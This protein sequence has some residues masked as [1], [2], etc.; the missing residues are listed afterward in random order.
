MNKSVPETIFP[1]MCDDIRQEVGGK[2][3][4]MG[5]YADNI[6]L[7]KFPFNFPKICFQIHMRGC[8][9][10]FILDIYLETPD[11]KLLLMKDF[12][13]Q[14]KDELSDERRNLILNINRHGIKFANPGTCSL[15]LIFN[16]EEE[17]A[18]S[19]PFEVSLRKD[20]H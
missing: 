7:T 16:Q 8:P 12:N 20:I 9:R 2:V 18:F 3:S 11:E 1:I 5:V 14:A 6:V 4:L 17:S 10:E 15:K 19:F 13:F